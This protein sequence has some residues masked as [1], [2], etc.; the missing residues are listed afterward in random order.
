M[1]GPSLDKFEPIAAAGGTIIANTSIITREVKRSD[2]KVIKIDAT[3][4]SSNELH[5][6]KVQNMVVL[7]AYLTL[8]PDFTD[9]EIERVLSDRFGARGA[10]LLPLNMEAIKRGKA[11]AS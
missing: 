6:L 3:N 8:H 10:S 4:I 7:G 11:G 2:V 9:A 5:S 1:N